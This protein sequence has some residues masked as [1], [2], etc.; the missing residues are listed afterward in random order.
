MIKLEM[1]NKEKTYYTPAGTAI[2]YARAKEKWPLID[3]VPMV[4]ET[5]VAGVMMMGMNALPILQTNLNIDPKLNA[6]GVIDEEAIIAEAEYTMNHMDEILA[7]NAPVTVE[8]RAV[9]VQEYNSMMEHGDV[10][11]MT[12]ATNAERG[13]WSKTM[14]QTGIATIA[15]SLSDEEAL[16][17]QP[18]V[19]QWSDVL[20]RGEALKAN[21]PFEHEGQLYRAV[22]D[23]VPQAHQQP[24]A[25]GMLAI[26]RPVDQVHAGTLEDP[27]PWREGMDCRA[28]SYYLYEGEVWKCASDMIPCVWHPGQTG[29]HGWVRM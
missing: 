23:I 7:A 12:L 15:H 1:Y 9:A 4:V 25:E 2:D 28:G 26:Y 8:E 24:G 14:A 3:D 5:D 18:I 11:V 27:I 21:E 29:V 17:L 22:I 16:A 6:D 10:A 13:T 20:A 19:K